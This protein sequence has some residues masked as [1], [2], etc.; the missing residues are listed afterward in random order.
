MVGFLFG[1]FSCLI[2]WVFCWFLFCFFGVCLLVIFLFFG[3][4]IHCKNPY[5][6]IQ[7][8]VFLNF[9]HE[10]PFLSPTSCET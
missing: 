7:C 5:L 3:F 6:S 9:W 8:I 2:V 1:L 4:F 10:Q